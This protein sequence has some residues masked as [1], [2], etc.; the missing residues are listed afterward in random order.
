MNGLEQNYGDQVDFRG[1]DVNGEWKSAF[2]TYRLL[3]HPS[4]VILN[5]NGEVEWSGVGEKSREDLENQILSALGT[6]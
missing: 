5:K 6:K 2:N 3:G 1:L 4:Y